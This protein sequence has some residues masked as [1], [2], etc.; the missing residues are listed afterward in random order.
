M[1]LLSPLGK[2]LEG[3]SPRFFR[4]LSEGV[5][6]LEDL[7][8]RTNELADWLTEAY[9]EYGVDPSKVVAVGYSNGATTGAALMMLRPETIGG[10]ILLRPSVPLEPDNLP[11]L[12]E[13]AVLLVPGQHDTIVSP[14]Q[15]S[16]LAKLLASAG[17]EVEVEQVASGHGLTETDVEIAKAWLQRLAT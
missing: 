16:M 7:V 17:A 14:V 5:F 4:R 13:K 6:D 2:V 3:R 9:V 15:G 11:D 1:S 8:F 10:G 12:A